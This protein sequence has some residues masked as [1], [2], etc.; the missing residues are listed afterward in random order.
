VTLAAVLDTGMVTPRTSYVLPYSIAVSDRVIHDAMPRGTE[1]MTVA[2]ILSRSSNVGVITLALG[3]GRDRLSQWIDRFGFGHPT[4][5]EYPGE[6]GGIVLPPQSWSGST[7]GN[8]PIGQGIAVTPLQMARAYATIANDGVAM[9]PHLI[10]RI[11]NDPE[12]APKGR[13]LVS[14]RTAT[15]IRSMLKNV[16]LDGSGVAAQIPGYVVAGKTGTAAKPD[17]ILGGYS[18][19]RYVSSFVGFVPAKN[20]R[21]VV[22]VTVDEPR[23]AIWGGTV[24]APA[25]KEIAQ[26]ALQY[27][28]VPPERPAEVAT[29]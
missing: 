25:F 28:E 17:P 26:F 8:V 4:G 1:R 6:T 9:R 15:Q 13:R 19:S 10:E 11:G 29:Q 3:L 14:E 2:E 7:I 27:L 23:G 22:L 24:A 18:T 20:P 5:I 21:F 16:V 12:R